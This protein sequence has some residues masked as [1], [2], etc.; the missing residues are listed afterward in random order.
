[1]ALKAA[2]LN[3]LG[4]VSAPLYLFGHF[5]QGKPSELL[6]PNLCR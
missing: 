5:F 2:V 6:I 3:A 4:F 1:M